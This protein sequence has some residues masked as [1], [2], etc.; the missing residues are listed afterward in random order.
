MKNDLKYNFADFTTSNYRMLIQ[1][2]KKSYTFSHFGDYDMYNQFIIMRHDIDYSVKS[3]LRLAQIENS[4]GITATYFILLHS[5]FYNIFE[6]DTTSQL[7][8]IISLGH[9]VGLL[10]DTSYYRIKNKKSLK[11]YLQFEKNIIDRL[12]EININ[13]FSFHNPNS[14]CLQCGAEKYSEMINVYSNRI[15]DTVSYCSDSNGYWRFRKLADV[16]QDPAVK[17]LQVL[18]HPEWWQESPMPPL[19]PQQPMS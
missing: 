6:S 3:A 5:E 15:M 2:A 12:L 14:F 16:L 7:Q 10:F 18:T 4:E 9:N 19:P 17:R 8:Q 1:M 13:V 11:K